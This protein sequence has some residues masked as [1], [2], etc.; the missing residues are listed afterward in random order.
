MI[1][2]VLVGVCSC[3]PLSGKRQLDVN[4]V[5]VF[6]VS[7]QLLLSVANSVA[8][9]VASMPILLVVAAAI[10]DNLVQMLLLD[11]ADNGY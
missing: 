5:T 2:A 10:V 1:S 4:V 9:A 8:A 6:F 7:L 3:S 11:L